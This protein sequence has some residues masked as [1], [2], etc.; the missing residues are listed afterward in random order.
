MSS[1][2]VHSASSSTGIPF[3]RR[4]TII[5]IFSPFFI[6]LLTNPTKKK[7]NKFFPGAK[8]H[9]CPNVKSKLNKFFSLNSFPLGKFNDFSVSILFNLIISLYPSKAAHGEITIL[10]LN[11][12]CITHSIFISFLPGLTLGIVH[13]TFCPVNNISSNSN[14]FFN[15]KLGGT[16]PFI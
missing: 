4:F 5:L 13:M 11:F 6:C 9:N 3:L 7:D 8:P 10:P 1:I 12:S 16:A 2:A 15:S 14:F